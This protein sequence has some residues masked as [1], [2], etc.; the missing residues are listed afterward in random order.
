MTC[1]VWI[2]DSVS[3]K[4][5]PPR[6]SLGGR[7]FKIHIEKIPFRCIIGEHATGRM[8]RTNGTAQRKILHI[9][10]CQREIPSAAIGP[11]LYGIL[12]RGTCLLWLIRGVPLHRTAWAGK[13]SIHHHKATYIVQWMTDCHRFYGSHTFATIADSGTNGSSQ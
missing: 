12:Q 11:E 5:L 13:G 8:I 7:L 3:I 1:G 9:S 6:V 10:Q 4:C 2:E